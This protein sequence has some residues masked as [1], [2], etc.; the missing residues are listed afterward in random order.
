[1]ILI[2]ALNGTIPSSAK[3]KKK[4]KNLAK[5][6]AKLERKAIRKLEKVVGKLPPFINPAA[7]KLTKKSSAGVVRVNH[8]NL[9]EPKILLRIL[10]A[11]KS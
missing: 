10:E 1:M 3:S 5:A 4:E 7:P 2:F 6:E 8:E 9:I 11:Q